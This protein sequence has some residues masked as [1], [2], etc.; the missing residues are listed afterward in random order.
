MQKNA[1]LA[2]A[3]SDANCGYNNVSFAMTPMEDETSMSA[4]AQCYFLTVVLSVIERTIVNVVVLVG[5]HACTNRGFLRLV[6]PVFFGCQTCFNFTVKDFLQL[7]RVLLTKL[8]K[9]LDDYI[10]KC[11]RRK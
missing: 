10:F 8:K 9:S 11:L 2:T 4:R 1:I 7:P 5:E 6:G 3:P